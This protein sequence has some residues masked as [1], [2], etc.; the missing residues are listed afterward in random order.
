MQTPNLKEGQDTRFHILA[1]V[2]QQIT[3]ILDIDELLVQVVRLIQKTF[4][5]YHVGIGLV[6]GDEIVYRVGAGA[7]WDDPDF[8]FKPSH[9]KIGSEGLTG[10]V[11]KAGEPALAPDVSQDP[12]YLVMQGSQA[13]S[14][15]VVPI[16][17]REQ[18]IGVLDVQSTQ[19]D[20]FS[21]SDLELMQSLASQAGVAIHNA[22]LY[23]RARQIAIMEERQRL[24]REL[25]D[26][27]TQALYGISLY[28]QAASAHLARGRHDKA[29]QYLDDI[30]STAQESLS[31][32]RLLIYEL[33]PPLLEKEGLI[34]VLQT[35]L[36]S[37]ED[38][39]G[40]KATLESNLTE[41]LPFVMEPGLYRIATEALNNALKHA[42]ARNVRIRL[43]QDGPTLTL[44]VVDDG[45]GF[46][47]E[48]A[49]GK[50]G[51]GMATMAERAQAH[52]WEL[53]VDSRP[54]EGTRV[55]IKAEVKR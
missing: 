31:D 52:G 49:D 41:R 32:M 17:V 6:E 28:A 13:Q 22:R 23:E 21:A 26:S 48:T 8:R 53:E 46:T 47:P 25:H 40:I 3:S 39:A 12:R 29:E 14:E 2:S 54:G 1:E 7:L 15:L 5:Y 16:I 37:V 24:A 11:A 43:M 38:R 55:T 19:L 42:H 50:G 33:R 44:Q 35:R 9:L 36:F 30:S 51:L 10:W 45:A 27:V 34:S 18:V 4:N 20:G